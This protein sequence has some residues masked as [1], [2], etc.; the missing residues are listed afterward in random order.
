MNSTL[1]SQRFRGFL[2]VVIDVETGG[3]DAKKDALL[4]V[5]AV[6]VNF[7]ENQ[8][9]CR[10]H[11]IHYHIHPFPGANIDPEA[12]KITGIDPYH[13][14]RP[15][16]HEDKAAERFFDEIRA[17]Q[18]QQECTRSI[19][20]GHNATFDLGFINA[21]A[22]RTD[23]KRNPFHPF[24]VLDTVSLGALAYGQTVLARIA[25]QGGFDYDSE[26]AHGAKYDAELT[27]DIFCHIINTWAEKIGYSWPASEEQP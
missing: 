10:S 3:F 4:E 13:P 19:L 2:P 15:A 26:K 18:K 5:A 22:E 25:R 14:L 27:A 1:I 24:S 20:V 8:R 17:Y 12:L 21:L 11:T 9:L 7:D 23:Y 16:Y 6:L